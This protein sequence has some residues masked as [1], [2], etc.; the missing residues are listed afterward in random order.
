M[1]GFSP[2][3]PSRGSPYL[4]DLFSRGYD[5]PQVPSRGMPGSSDHLDQPT[6]SLFAPLHVGCH[7][8]TG[9]GKHSLPHIWELPVNY[10]DF[11]VVM[12]FYLFFQRTKRILVTAITGFKIYIHIQSFMFFKYDNNWVRQFWN[13]YGTY[14]YIYI[15]I[16]L[17]VTV[18]YFHGAVIFPL[19]FVSFG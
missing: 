4:L 18:I 15:S 1:G 8:Y 13:Y 3:S 14:I 7:C 16:Y 6:C 19:I 17:Y 9:G 10:R 2:P 12:V 11:I 5:M